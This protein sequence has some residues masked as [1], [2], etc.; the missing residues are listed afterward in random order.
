MDAETTITNDVLRLTS[1]GTS[2]G[3]AGARAAAAPA[4]WRP[5]LVDGI[6]GFISGT[7]GMVGTT[8]GTS[9]GI[10]RAPSVGPSSGG[11]LA[12]Q[13]R[14]AQTAALQ[15]G[16]RWFGRGFVLGGSSSSS[17]ST[18]SSSEDSSGG[19]T[20]AAASSLEAAQPAA[21]RARAGDNYAS[22][23][24]DGGAAAATERRAK[25]AMAA[26]AR[27]SGGTGRGQNTSGAHAKIN[28]KLATQ[29]RKPPNDNVNAHL[30]SLDAS[31]W[32]CAHCRRRS[33]TR[34]RNCSVS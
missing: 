17:S 9:G 31:G 14:A 23:V 19:A 5:A 8:P 30:P 29:V 22:A 34:S 16:E 20:S 26:M 15:R 1:S 11:L 6:A 10:A 7:V 21:K 3:G 33:T 32:L 25:A 27:F 28:A 18:S 2:P 24:G 12:A 4:A 13:R